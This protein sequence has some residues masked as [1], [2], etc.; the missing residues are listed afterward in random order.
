MSSTATWSVNVTLPTFAA[1]PSPNTAP[2]YATDPPA[3]LQVE[4]N[5]Q[6][7]YVLGPFSDDEN[8][9]VTGVLTSTSSAGSIVTLSADYT[10]LIFNPVCRTNSTTDI[11]I[12]LTDNNALSPKSRIYVITVETTYIPP[13]KGPKPSGQSPSEDEDS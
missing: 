6:V 1:M 8:D 12:S 2:Y 10:T 5:K 9:K 7:D 3:T 11:K 4:C 13:S